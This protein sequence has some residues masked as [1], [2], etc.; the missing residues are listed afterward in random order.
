MQIQR[1]KRFSRKVG[2]VAVEAVVKRELDNFGG[3]ARKRL[4]L[5]PPVLCRHQLVDID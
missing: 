5:A 4:F 3:C 1:K 2:D